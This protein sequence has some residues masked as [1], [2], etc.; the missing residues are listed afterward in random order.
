MQYLLIDNSNTRT[1]FVLADEQG[2][3]GD[4][5]RVE[6]RSLS[7][8]LL[9]T[10]TAG[11]APNAILLCSVV[12]EKAALMKSFFTENLPDA[13][14]H[15]LKDDSPHGIEIDYPNPRQIGAD[16]L[17]NAIGVDHL[18]GTP[19]IVIDF[20]T[21]VTFDVIA[22][23][24][25]YQGGVI[26]PGLGAMTDYLANKTALLPQIELSE[27]ETAIGK[28]TE[29]AMHA[30]AVYGYR[31]L[32]KEII[33]QIQSDMKCKAMIITTGGDGKLIAD[34]LDEVDHFCRNLTLEGIRIAAQRIFASQNS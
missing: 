32:V 5:T 18:Y 3:L 17:V 15:Q 16:R 31:G 30:G 22:S 29:Q 4:V 11:M 28:S 23:G 33:A 10:V 13:Q 21:A 2:L 14:F 12:P 9:S 25:V 7:E 19:A 26:A 34:G 6:T 24:G 27:P 1:K 8:D 20:G